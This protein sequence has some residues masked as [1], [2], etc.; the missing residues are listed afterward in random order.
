MRMLFRVGIAC[1]H[2]FGAACWHAKQVACLAS[3]PLYSGM[4]LICCCHF[5]RM[6]Q[7][8]M[9]V[10]WGNTTSTGCSAA[11][12]ITPAT[13]VHGLLACCRLLQAATHAHG[14]GVKLERD[15]N[16]S[17]LQRMRQV[18]RVVAECTHPCITVRATLTIILCRPIP[19]LFLAS[20]FP[21]PRLQQPQNECQLSV[22]WQPFPPF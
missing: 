4:H 12:C 10:G 17:Y 15:A 14:M 3:Q 8:T 13:S 1:L 7:S 22:T 9:Q 6:I 19:A 20:P 16:N 2:M 11:D 5:C 18:L 21:P